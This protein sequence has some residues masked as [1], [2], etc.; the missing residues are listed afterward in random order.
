MNFTKNEKIN[1]G[2]LMFPE[3]SVLLLHRSSL[4]KVS[5][6]EWPFPNDRGEL[7]L[8]Q[9]REITIRFVTKNVPK[10]SSDGPNLSDGVTRVQSQ[11]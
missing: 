1:L 8:S 3:L 6:F 9:M 2:L 11:D 4:Y 5:P 10:V 7:G